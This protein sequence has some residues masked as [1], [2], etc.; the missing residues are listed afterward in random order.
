M[1]ISYQI[2]DQKNEKLLA[3]CD[4]ELLGETLKEGEL[5]LEIKKSFYGGK[6]VEIDKIVNQFESSTIANLVGERTVNI[7]LENGFGYEEDILW[8]EGVPHLQIVRL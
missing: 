3:A 6:E 5:H 8:I 2:Y 7:A 1:K 4:K